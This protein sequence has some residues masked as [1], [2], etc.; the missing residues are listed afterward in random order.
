MW[1]QAYWGLS[2]DALIR[3]IHGR[4][5]RHIGRVAEPMPV[6]LEREVGARRGEDETELR[7]IRLMEEPDPRSLFAAEPRILPAPQLRAD[8]GPA[9]PAKPG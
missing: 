8:F 3:T 5:L 1:P 4:V 2:S 7:P 6:G 9:H